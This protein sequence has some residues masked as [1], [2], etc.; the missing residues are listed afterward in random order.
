MNPAK[1]S[2]AKDDE[3]LNLLSL[4]P[5]LNQNIQIILFFIN[6]VQLSSYDFFSPKVLTVPQPWYD[7]LNQTDN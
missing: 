3:T 6:P 4:L 5:K 1:E 2:L 7:K